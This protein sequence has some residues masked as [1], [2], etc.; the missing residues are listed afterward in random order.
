[1]STNII[2][3][4]KEKFAIEIKGIVNGRSSVAG[5]RVWINKKTFGQ[6]EDAG[7]IGVSVSAFDHLTTLEN[8][9]NIDNKTLKNRSDIKL[10]YEKLDDR[11]KFWNSGE[12]FDDFYIA[13]GKSGGDIAFFGPWLNTHFIT[14]LLMNLAHITKP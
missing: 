3:G 2:F 11:L 1:M 8:L 12:S 7:V 6:I 14:T 13:I 10:N 9:S 4:E 5:I